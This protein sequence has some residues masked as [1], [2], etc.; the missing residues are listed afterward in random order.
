M[1][2]DPDQDEL[3][4]GVGAPQSS[5]VDK[6]T[7][8]ARESLQDGRE[9]KV[10][11]II[12]A[13]DERDDEADV[14]DAVADKRDQAAS[15]AAFLSSGHTYDETLKARRSAAADRLDSKSD[16]ASSARD[17]SELTDGGREDGTQ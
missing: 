4:T 5:A 7:L 17:R 14:R 15:L 6:A 1:T 11:Q 13:A 16:R 12:A 2:P 9:E 10:Q 3:A 8:I